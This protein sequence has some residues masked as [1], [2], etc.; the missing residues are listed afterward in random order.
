MRTLARLA[1]SQATVASSS[2][3]QKRAIRVRG[4]GKGLRKPG[5]QELPE[6]L[7]SV[8]L[9]LVLPVFLSDLVPKPEPQRHGWVD[10][11]DVA[12]RRERGS[13]WVMSEQGR[14]DGRIAPAQAG[15]SEHGV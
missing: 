13:F 5:F 8:W 3:S 14:P 9:G 1:N 2:S 6:S 11:N 7:T 4:P 12:A 15:K 10:F